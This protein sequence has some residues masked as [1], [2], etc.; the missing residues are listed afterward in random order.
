MDKNADK[1]I[2]NFS[3]GDFNVIVSRNLIIKG[4]IQTSITPKVLSLLIELAKH[5]GETLS[6]D[7]L[8]IA[9]WGTVHTTDMVLSR[10][11]SDLRKV[12]GDSARTQDYIETVSKQGYRLKKSVFWQENVAHQEEI[13]KQLHLTLHKQLRKLLKT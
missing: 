12:L 7:H 1:P 9:V 8:I 4:E 2:S 10:A 5:Q 13:T 3:V 11:M 6:K